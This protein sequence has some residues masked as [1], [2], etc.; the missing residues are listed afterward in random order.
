MFLAEFVSPHLVQQLWQRVN[1][2]TIKGLLHM[3]LAMYLGVA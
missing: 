3:P 2:E 1:W